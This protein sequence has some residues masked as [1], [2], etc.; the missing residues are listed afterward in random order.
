[1]PMPRLVEPRTA[2]LPDAWTSHGCFETMRAYFEEAGLQMNVVCRSIE[3]VKRVLCLDSE[4]M[5][6]A[7]R[8]LF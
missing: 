6:P 2:L 3:E 5:Y 1:M 4:W 8:L 7:R